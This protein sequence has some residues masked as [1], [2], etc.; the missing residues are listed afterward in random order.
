MHQTLIW[1]YWAD[2]DTEKG[3]FDGY[4]AYGPAT[5]QL[6]FLFD[7]LSDLAKRIRDEAY[8]SPLS[9][10]IDVTRLQALRRIT[11]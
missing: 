4:D 7:R 3:I 8:E 5:V 9:R 10:R 1:R 2:P 11:Q 6:V